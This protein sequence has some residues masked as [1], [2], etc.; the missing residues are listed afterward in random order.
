MWF[1]EVLA[2]NQSYLFIQSLHGDQRQLKPAILWSIFFPKCPTLRKNKIILFAKK[3]Q[4]TKKITSRDRDISITFPQ[5][6]FLYHSFFFQTLRKK[7]RFFFNDTWI[8]FLSRILNDF[9]ILP[10][11][12]KN[13]LKLNS[14]FK[15]SEVTS[16]WIL[17]FNPRLKESFASV[18]WY[19]E[20]ESAWSQVDSTRR[21]PLTI[22]Q[23]KLENA[24]LDT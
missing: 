22:Q 14:E 16:L 2:Q 18:S 9:T 23:N 21:L 3:R 7:K 11:L 5:I 24:H 6:K 4:Q 17:S 15:S 1:S 12:D 8:F 13:G 20:L 19:W 10:Y